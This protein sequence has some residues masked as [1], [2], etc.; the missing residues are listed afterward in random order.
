MTSTLPETS[1]DLETF[2]P[3][4]RNAS[5]R[6][7]EDAPGFAIVSGDYIVVDRSAPPLHGHL[8]AVK[9]EG[10]VSVRV[11]EFRDCDGD[12]LFKSGRAGEPDVMVRPDSVR[13]VGRVVGVL[14]R[15]GRTDL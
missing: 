7:T 6:M 4:E 2:F 8:C 9:F 12:W 13:V 15:Y 5:Y 1:L 11:R 3:G 10:D 14:R